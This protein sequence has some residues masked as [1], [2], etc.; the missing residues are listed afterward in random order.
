MTVGDGGPNCD[1][2]EAN[3]SDNFLSLGKLLRFFD[4]DCLEIPIRSR[5]TTAAQLQRCL[6]S[7]GE[8]VSKMV[9]CLMFD[10]L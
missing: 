4:S 8:T 7:Y 6:F 3:I 5:S 9:G 2:Q 1:F 10:P